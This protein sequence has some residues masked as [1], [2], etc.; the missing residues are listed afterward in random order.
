[1]RGGDLVDVGT[2]PRMWDGCGMAESGHPC[3]AVIVFNDAGPLSTRQIRMRGAVGGGE[4]EVVPASHCLSWP[5]FEPEH[6]LTLVSCVAAC[7]VLGVAFCLEGCELPDKHHPEQ[8]DTRCQYR[9]APPACRMRS[10]G[11]V[12][13]TV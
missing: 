3:R 5:I 12:S 9:M 13:V 1:M 2:G 11:M 8:K 6:S 10:V 7:R 4:A